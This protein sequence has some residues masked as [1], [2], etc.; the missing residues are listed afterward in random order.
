M[1]IA[2]WL[3]SHASSDYGLLFMISCWIIWKFRNKEVIQNASTNTWVV[4]HQ[5]HNL[6]DDV[7]RAF[8]YNTM[9][10]TTSQIRWTPPPEGTSKLNA[11][12]S[13]LGTLGSWVS[14]ELSKII[15]VDGR[16]FSKE[17]T[18][19]ICE[20]DSQS[21]INMIHDDVGIYHPLYPLV[22]KIRSFRHLHWSLTFRHLQ[23]SL[24]FRHYPKEGNQVADGLAKKGSSDGVP[25]KVW[26]QCPAGLSPKLMAVPL[27]ISVSFI[28]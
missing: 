10:R 18:S 2:D 23:W 8:K 4:L 16:L 7:S 17:I 12:G 27:C 11:D 21:T 26:H 5:I 24:T 3:H 20:S 14:V 19:L 28:F 13:S 1:N 15:G 9:T 6:F 22:N 25:F